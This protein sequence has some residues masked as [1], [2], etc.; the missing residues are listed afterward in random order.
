MKARRSFKARDS[1]PRARPASM[2]REQWIA[3]LRWNVQDATEALK[4]AVY[5]LRTL[6]SPSGCGL[7]TV[8]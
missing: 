7:R 3:K 1:R 5:G 8:V 2:T 4:N 6:F